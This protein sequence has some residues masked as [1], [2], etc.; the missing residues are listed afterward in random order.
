MLNA[1]SHFLFPAF[2]HS[3]S[4]SFIHVSLLHPFSVYFSALCKS[5]RALMLIANYR[6]RCGRNLLG[7]CCV[8]LFV[9]FKSIPLFQEFLI[10]CLKLCSPLV[11]PNCSPVVSGPD[12][13]S[14]RAVSPATDDA[15]G[16]G[17]SGLLRALHL[18]F[19]YLNLYLFSPLFSYFLRYY[20]FPF[21]SVD[22]ITW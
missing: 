15:F 4:Y 3:L 9:F 22:S 8:S 18:S 20:Y 6:G 2:L 7:L 1:N 13:V 12:N 19:N 21:E 10:F 11:L 17:I 5:I 14:T 16:N